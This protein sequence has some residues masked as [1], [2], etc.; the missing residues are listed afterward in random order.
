MPLLAI[1]DLRLAVMVEAGAVSELHWSTV[2]PWKTGLTTQLDTGV[3]DWPCLKQ[4]I[5]RLAVMM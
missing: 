1:D 2:S 5:D 3:G 4:V